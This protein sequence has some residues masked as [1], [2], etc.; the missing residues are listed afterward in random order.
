MDIKI[1]FHIQIVAKL[2]PV[3]KTEDN[4]AIGEISKFNYVE[5]QQNTHKIGDR[6][7]GSENDFEMIWVHVGDD[8]FKCIGKWYERIC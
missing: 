7:I 6:V 3:L 1:P 8:Y 5:S 4:L 2:Y